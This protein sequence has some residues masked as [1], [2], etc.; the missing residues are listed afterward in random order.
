MGLGYWKAQELGWMMVTV[1]LKEQD[2]GQPYEPPKG[3][4]YAEHDVMCHR[5]SFSRSLPFLFHF[6]FL[7]SIQLP[8]YLSHFTRSRPMT[9][10]SNTLILVQ[11]GLAICGGLQSNTSRF[12]VV[13]RTFKDRSPIVLSLNELPH[14]IK[15]VTL[16][17]SCCRTWWGKKAKLY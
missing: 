3:N 14:R 8:H 16:R 4:I 5:A 12:Y 11:Y 15:Q 17:R 10:Q 6:H 9:R 1:M 2:L 13:P 7:P